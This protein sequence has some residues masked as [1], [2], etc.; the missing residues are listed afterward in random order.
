MPRANWGCW[1][2]VHTQ[3]PRANWGWWSDVHTQEPPMEQ[4]H[5]NGQFDTTCS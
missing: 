5:H 2:D 3:E 4:L 1:S